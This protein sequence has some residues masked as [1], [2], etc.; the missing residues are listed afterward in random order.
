VAY[1]R[2]VRTTSRRRRGS[3]RIEHLGSAHSD[4]EVAALRLFAAERIAAGQD[5]LD[6]GLAA[7]SGPLEVAGSTAGHRHT[8]VADAEMLSEA[9]AARGT[10]QHGAV[11]HQH[12]ILPTNSSSAGDLMSRGAQT[13]VDQ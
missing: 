9:N 13:E 5:E 7:G 4:A 11:G 10:A 8:V 6:L 3:R 12:N 1:V 2:T